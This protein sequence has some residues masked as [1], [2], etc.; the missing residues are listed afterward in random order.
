MQNIQCPDNAEVFYLPYVPVIRPLC[1][2]QLNS[3][4]IEVT[5]LLALL[6][7]NR[8]FI[9]CNGAFLVIVRHGATGILV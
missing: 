6:G 5:E 9:G 7:A 1:Q 2:F 8:G 3:M 4:L